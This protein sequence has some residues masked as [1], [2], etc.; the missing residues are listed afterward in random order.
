MKKRQKTIT[1]VG[2]LL[3]LF[4]GF[5]MAFLPLQAGAEDFDTAEDFDIDGD[6]FLNIYEMG[7]QYITVPGY[8]QFT[9][10]PYKADLVILLENPA[11]LPLPVYP[12]EFINK[13]Y[14]ASMR[15]HDIPVDDG[16]GIYDQVITLEQNALLLIIDPATDDGDLGASEIAY[17]AYSDGI[18]GRV[19]INRIRDDVVKG[20]S[21]K[22]YCEA[23][24]SAGDV[25]AVGIEN[26]VSFFIKNV[27]AH[28][29][30][31]ML[32]RVVP[33]NSKVDYHYAQLNYVMDHHVY[34]KVYK[35]PA[36]VTWFIADRWS[37]SD[38]PRFIK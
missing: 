1:Q 37:T 29:T 9:P 6:G 2:L 28:E 4:A 14:G 34:Y 35:T 31:H 10:D 20:C 36:K 24:N 32:G 30:F 17:P 18:Q 22:S 7:S 33:V 27:I 5:T 26:I 3:L 12:F 38:I 8:G 13:S 11:D 25:V 19:F 16:G 15:I 23:V 21:L